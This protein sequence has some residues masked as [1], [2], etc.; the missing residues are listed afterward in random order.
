MMHKQISRS[1]IRTIA[2]FFC[3]AGLSL[4]S[5]AQVKSGAAM[6]MLRA[7]LSQSLAMSAAPQGMMFNSFLGTGPATDFPVTITTNW[8]KGPGKV[9]VAVIPSTFRGG[10][11]APVSVLQPATQRVDHVQMPSPES[12]SQDGVT[13]PVAAEELPTVATQ[14]RE[15]KVD[16]WGLPLPTEG[17]KEVLIVRAQVI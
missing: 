16:T 6:I 14:S 13:A 12:V 3:I 7:T 9:S 5:A 8:I 1:I 17:K 2:L 4:T 10:D 15:L 11:S